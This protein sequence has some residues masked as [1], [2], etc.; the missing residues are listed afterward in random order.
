MDG[1]GLMGVVGREMRPHDPLAEQNN[2]ITSPS[3]GG[4]G[5]FSRSCGVLALAAP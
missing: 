3:K 4:A 5:L 1:L 2:L